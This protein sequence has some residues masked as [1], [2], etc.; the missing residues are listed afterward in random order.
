MARRTRQRPPRNTAP[1]WKK[2]TIVLSACLT[3]IVVLKYTTVWHMGLAASLV[4]SLAAVAGVL[5]LVSRLLGVH[6]GLRS[7]D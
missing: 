2:F 6:L 1:N 4:L 3:M 5:W 7:W